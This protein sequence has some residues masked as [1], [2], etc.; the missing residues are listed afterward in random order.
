VQGK[1]QAPSGY[2]PTVGEKEKKRGEGGDEKEGR[3]REREKGPQELKVLLFW[4][5]NRWGGF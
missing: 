4:S 5:R 3:R 2:E 1:F